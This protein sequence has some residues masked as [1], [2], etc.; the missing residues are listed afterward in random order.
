M[1]AGKQYTISKATKNVLEELDDPVT[2]EFFFSADL[3]P[4]LI[5][6]RDEVKDKLAEYAAYSHGKFKLRYIDPGTDAAKKEEGRRARA[7]ASSRCRW[8]RRTRPA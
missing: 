1:T 2:A 3:P 7:C 8:W 4:Q 5:R 6:M